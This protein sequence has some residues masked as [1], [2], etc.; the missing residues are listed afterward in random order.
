MARNSMEALVRTKNLIAPLVAEKYVPVLPIRWRE[1]VNLR[2]CNG[3]EKVG[4]S[5]CTI[6]PSIKTEEPNG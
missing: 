4:T 3:R 2:T 1:L 5:W 6:E